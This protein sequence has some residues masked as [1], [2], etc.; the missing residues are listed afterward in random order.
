MR[1]QHG[2]DPDA[3]RLG[4]QLDVRAET[5]TFGF[6]RPALTVQAALPP[7]GALALAFEG[8]VGTTLETSPVQSSWYLGGTSSLRGYSSGALHGPAFWRG[9]A[10][11]ATALP[12]A[13]L[14]VFS[15]VG[16]AGEARNDAFRASRPLLSA[17]AGVSLLDGILRL[18]LARALRAPTGWRLHFYMDARL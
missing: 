11:L 16:W 15:D 3:L 4:A 6:V 18:D 1:A 9:R 12:A 5:G 10:E 14:A 7:V 2:E 13:R 17:G 8:G